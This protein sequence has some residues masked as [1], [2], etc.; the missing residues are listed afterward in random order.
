[1]LVILFNIV[2]IIFLNVQ[3]YCESYRL[4]WNI[5]FSPGG[6]GIQ[7]NGEEIAPETA[8]AKC[9]VICIW[10]LFEVKIL[11]YHTVLYIGAVLGPTRFLIFER[12]NYFLNL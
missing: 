8:T 10:R 7:Q 11:K 5:L 1:M 9:K 12:K 2:P 6:L 4:F 3:R